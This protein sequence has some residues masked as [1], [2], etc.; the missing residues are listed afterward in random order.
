MAINGG[1]REGAGKKPKAVADA[2][3]ASYVKY[4]K[5]R[6][7]KEQSNAA[8]AK[9]ALKEKQGS[10]VGVVQMRKEA[11]QSARAVRNAFL[12]LPERIASILVGRDEKDI[13]FA[14]RREVRDTLD[15]LADEID[16]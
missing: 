1:K 15:L 5:A 7:E 6:A 3:G 8:M 11:D 4:S 13:L 10:L 16:I 14:L 2:S 12:A 9:L